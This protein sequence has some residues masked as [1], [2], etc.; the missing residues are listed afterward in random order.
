MSNSTGNFTY[1]TTN[2]KIYIP[3]AGETWNLTIYNAGV[4]GAN[5]SSANAS[6]TANPSLEN[7][8]FSLYTTNSIN[9]TFRDEQTGS[10]LYDGTF[11]TNFYHIS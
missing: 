11:I 2:G 6:V 5:Y 8:T 9:F 10:I 4:T 3:I 7:Y 1:S